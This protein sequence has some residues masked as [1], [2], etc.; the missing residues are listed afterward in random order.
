VIAVRGGPRPDAIA[1]STFPAPQRVRSG[2][3]GMP[4]F[5]PL[6]AYPTATASIAGTVYLSG[7]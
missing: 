1:R 5:P 7:D 4:E 6:A 3:V 2:G